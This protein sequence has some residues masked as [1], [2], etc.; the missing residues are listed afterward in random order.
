[1]TVGKKIGFGV[2]AAVWLALCVVMLA[3]AGVTLYNLLIVIISGIIVFVPIWK[4]YSDHDE[5]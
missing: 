5:Q 4:K 3:K 2:L 1:M